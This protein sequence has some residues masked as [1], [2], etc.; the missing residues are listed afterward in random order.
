MKILHLGFLLLFA[1]SCGRF[2]SHFGVGGHYNAGKEQIVKHRAADLDKAIASLETVVRE[3]P[4]YRDSLTLLGRAYYGKKRYSDAMLI[5]QRAL[6]VDQKDEI[7][8]LTLG[9]TQLRRGED[10]KGLET[11][12]GGLTLLAKASVDGYK[13]YEEWDKGGKV[14]IALRRAVFAAQK[15]LQDGTKDGLI[16]SVES[17]LASIDDEIFLQILEKRREYRDYSD[18][19]D[20]GDN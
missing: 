3:D 4:T 17:T 10:Q 20:S 11:V 9:L 13:G 15:G 7:A 1:V 12:R 19:D 16:R 2:G 14:N 8:W 5:L 6:V 18:S